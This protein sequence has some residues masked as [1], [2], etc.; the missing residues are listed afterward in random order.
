[1]RESNGV[2][3]ASLKD[4]RAQSVEFEFESSRLAESDNWT[5]L[6][7]SEDIPAGWIQLGEVALTGRG[8]ATGCNEFF[9]LSRRQVFE[10][11]ISWSNVRP[12]IGKSAHVSE[13]IFQTCD[14]E[15]LILDDRRVYLVDFQSDLNP[16]EYEYILKA[17]N[18]AIN[19]R[20]LLK[21]RSPWYSMEKKPVFPIWV[22]VFKRG[23]ARFVRNSS[24]AL[25]LTNFH[26]I[27]PFDDRSIFHD[28]LAAVLNSPD[29]LRI[30]G[31]ASRKFG[32]GLTKFEPADL[33]KVWL[34]DIRRAPDAI[35]ESL[36]GCL[37][38]LDR[39]NRN[40]D[41]PSTSE[42]RLATLV[43]EIQ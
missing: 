24:G 27:L 20:F 34:P 26:G 7:D 36:A 35:L 38:D 10:L 32:G 42:N 14:L 9:L 4:L 37:Q 22:S 41:D 33:K 16:Y 3:P 8:I 23:G 39:N 5:E 13:L 29:V 6:L 28:A 15:A 1:M 18:E 12:C 11:G 25:S 30:S 19:D 21:N 31:R 17:E 43:R 40:G 2:R